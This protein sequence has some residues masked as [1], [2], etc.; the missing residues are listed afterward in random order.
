MFVSCDIVLDGSQATR[1]SYR[2]KPF[3]ADSRIGNPFSKQIVKNSG[4]PGKHCLGGL[5]PLQSVRLEHETILLEPPEFCFGC[6]CTAFQFCKIDFLQREIIS[7][8][9]LHFL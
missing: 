4:I 5:T 2:P 9:G 1:K 7:L 6:T 3:Q 8:L